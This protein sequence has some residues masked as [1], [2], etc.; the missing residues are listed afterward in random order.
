[1]IAD[2]VPLSSAVP[3]AGTSIDLTKDAWPII[4]SE[5]E[6]RELYFI[7]ELR[8][9]DGSCTPSVIEAGADI[10][11]PER[12]ESHADVAIPAV[13]IR[14]VWD[15]PFVFTPNVA[16]DLQ[17]AAPGDYVQRDYADQYG[18]NIVVKNSAGAG[19]VG[20]VDVQAWGVGRIST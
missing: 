11:F 20:S 17:N 15:Y 4:A 18:V 13:G 16:I 14:L 6:A 9:L 3:L 19:K 7:I 8:S 5:I 12:R 1:M 2:W 10:D